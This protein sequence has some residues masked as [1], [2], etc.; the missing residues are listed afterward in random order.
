MNSRPRLNQLIEEIDFIVAERRNLRARGVHLI[1]T[2]LYHLPGTIC[3]PGEMIGDVSLG[4][5]P[6]PTSFG[7]SHLSLLMVDCFCRYRLPLTA[8]RIEQIMNSDPFYGDGNRISQS[9][10]GLAQNYVNDIAAG[11]PVVLQDAIGEGPTGSYVYGLNLIEAFQPLSN[12]FY[13]YDGLGSV[14]LRTD[15]KGRAETAYLYDAWGNAILPAPPTNP[16]RFTGE[17][18]DPGTGFYYLRARYYDPSTGRFIS[19]DPAQGT[20]SFPLSLNRYD[21]VLSNPLRFADPS[22]LTAQDTAQTSEGSPL[23]LGFSLPNMSNNPQFAPSGNAVVCQGAADCIADALTIVSSVPGSG[24]AVG[25]TS[26]IASSYRDLSQAN[27]SSA[28]KFLS[29]G[30]ETALLVIG[31]ADPELG[32]GLGLELFLVNETENAPDTFPVTTPSVS[33]PIAPFQLPR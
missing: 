4:G 19:R 2:H 15:I 29:V 3:A 21:Y 10:R 23:A 30:T 11:P 27:E 22:G 14:T 18:L 28:Y 32:A 13:Q 26:F 24:N 12:D 5:F 17:A 6:S 31:L 8:W 33:S 7:F 16:F 20:A 1:V 9:T 25:V